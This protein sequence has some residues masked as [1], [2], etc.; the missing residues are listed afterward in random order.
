VAAG[1]RHWLILL[2]LVALWG[3]SYLMIEIA[4]RLW[5]P[6]QIT[7]LRVVAGLS[8]LL[9][10]MIVAGQRF[11]REPRLWAY[12]LM[13][14]V[15]GNCMPFFLISWG[16]QQVESGL[17]GIL[18]ATMPLVVLLVAHLVLPDERLSWRQGIAFLVGFAGI[19]TLMGPD[20]LAALGGSADRL[21]AQLAVFAGAVCYAVS[22]VGA[23]LLPPISSL[24]TAATVLLI[25]TLLMAPFAV[26]GALLLP[27]VTP[28]VG[29]A[30]GILGF[31]G[32]GFAS[33]LYFYLIAQTSARF[34]S[35]LNYLV[36]I[37][38]VALGAFVLGE[39]LPITSWFAL[40]LILTGLA[41]SQ[42][43]SR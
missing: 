16:Q 20:S 26:D 18:A 15:V 34:V 43:A 31:L 42:R 23:R 28:A 1:G 17:A 24:V 30:L 7:G 21:V 9:V 27:K 8:V 19:V 11:P 4:L 37:W 13:F 38:A 33:I 32:T 22:T 40:G 3:S 10:A 41:I 25:A 39:S 12:F 36:P 14:A 6:A 29:L 5:S 2:I 35:Y